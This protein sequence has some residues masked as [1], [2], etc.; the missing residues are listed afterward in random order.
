MSYIMINADTVIHTTTGSIAWLPVGTTV[1]L[2]V[3]F[4]DDIGE[5]FFATNNKVMYR[6]N[7]CVLQ[8]HLKVIHSNM[9]SQF[10]YRTVGILRLNA[11]FSTL[12]LS[13]LL[14]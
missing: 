1:Q 2:S 9:I 6:P 14:P 4:H 13:D 8:G 10:L 12:F 3:T 5:M 11:V 7:R